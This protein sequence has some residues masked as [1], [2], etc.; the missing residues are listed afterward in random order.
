MPRRTLHCPLCPPHSSSLSM[1]LT[2]PPFFS[3]HRSS[4][5]TCPEGLHFPTLAPA[6]TG[7][8]TL[9]RSHLTVPAASP[10]L[11]VIPP[12]WPLPS[13]PWLPISTKKSWQNVSAIRMSL[14]LYV[15]CHP[16][17]PRRSHLRSWFLGSCCRVVV[18]WW[19]PSPLVLTDY[20]QHGARGARGYQGLNPGLPGVK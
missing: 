5:A 20:S 12:S 6:K 9:T 19:W 18:A 8:G 15:I 7:A 2:S 14:P 1:M 4:S 3:F 17:C 13:P 11:R 10:E 16:C